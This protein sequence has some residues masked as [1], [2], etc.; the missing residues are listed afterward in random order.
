[1]SQINANLAPSGVNPIER[2]VVTCPTDQLWELL[3]AVDPE[4]T[5]FK[6]FEVFKETQGIRCDNYLPWDDAFEGGTGYI[7]RIELN[8]LSK[9]AM[10]GIARANRPHITLKYSCTNEPPGKEMGSGVV[11]LFQRYAKTQK[12]FS[13]GADPERGWFG[14]LFPWN[15]KS[16]GSEVLVVDEGAWHSGSMSSGGHYYECN[17]GPLDLNHVSLPPDFYKDLR[18]FLQNEKLNIVDSDE[19]IGSLRLKV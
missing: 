2:T 14:A 8:H 1:M 12:Q 3:S 7:D 5:V 13:N 9:S 10:W 19:R 16:E 17:L 18:S 15:S 11:T 6:V 4:S